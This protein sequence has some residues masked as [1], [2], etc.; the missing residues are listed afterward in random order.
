MALTHGPRRFKF[1][2]VILADFSAFQYMDNEDVT[3]WA[4]SRSAVDRS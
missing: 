2:E 4:V 3:H 1:N